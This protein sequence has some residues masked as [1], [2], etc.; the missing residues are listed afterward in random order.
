ML[1]WYFEVVS[2]SLSV[3]FVIVLLHR[4]AINIETGAEVVY[5]HTFDP[6]GEGIKYVNVVSA[7][8]RFP[9]KDTC[10]WLAHRDNFNKRARRTDFGMTPNAC[11]GL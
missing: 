10:R 3:L 2:S 11:E 7:L 6:G 1:K 9:L 4:S 8:S 5:L